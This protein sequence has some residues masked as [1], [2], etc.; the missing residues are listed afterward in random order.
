MDGVFKGEIKVGRLYLLKSGEEILINSQQYEAEY[1]DCKRGTIHYAPISGL[2]KAIK[3]E[4]N[5]GKENKMVSDLGIA[6]ENG[7][8][9]A[10]DDINGNRKGYNGALKLGSDYM[11]Y[12]GAIVTITG[13]TDR[14][15]PEETTVHYCRKGAKYPEESVQSSVKDFKKMVAFEYI[16]QDLGGK[17]TA[18]IPP[19]NHIKPSHYKL[20][21]GREAIDIIKEI[22]TPEQFIGFLRGN[23]FKYDIRYKYKGGVEDLKKAEWYKTKLIEVESGK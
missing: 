4:L 1:I 3:C 8:L 5:E 23:I 16:P 7:K 14:F 15:N 19:S 22:L 11:L 12:P 18:D 6:A 2:L 21:G 17:I 9:L 10:T 20:S 13:F